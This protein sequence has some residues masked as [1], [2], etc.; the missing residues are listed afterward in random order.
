MAIITVT[1]LILNFA[2]ACRA[3]V[4]SLN[5]AEVLWGDGQQGN[6][7]DRVAE[8]LFRTLVS[9]P[10]AFHA[11]GEEG[12]AKLQILPYGFSP[13]SECN[14]W[15]TVEDGRPDRMVDL[16]SVGHPFDHVRCGDPLRLVPLT[17]ARFAFVHDNGGGLQMR[18][19]AVDLE[20]E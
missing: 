5:R 17:S 18:V 8:A 20:A 14:A 19:D 15:F 16:A 4:P 11:V 2:E 1:D 3:L 7:W 13:S 9:E 6:N 12:A 10:C